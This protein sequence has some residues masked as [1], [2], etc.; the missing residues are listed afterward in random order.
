MPEIVMGDQAISPGWLGDRRVLMRL[1][2][3]IWLVP[4]LVITVM[5]AL[6]PLQRTVT[7]VYHQASADW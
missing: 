1:G 2:V 3:L 6:R 5:V 7:P 4:F